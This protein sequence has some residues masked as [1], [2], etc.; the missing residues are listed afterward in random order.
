M[1]FIYYLEL[2]LLLRCHY[3][4]MQTFRSL[5][6][7]SQSALLFYL[8]FQY[9]ILH[10]LISVCTQFHHLFLGYLLLTKLEISMVVIYVKET[11]SLVHTH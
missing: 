7:Y 1:G 2:L 11:Q 5:T 9:V 10:L 8:S 4:Q 6:D 3:S